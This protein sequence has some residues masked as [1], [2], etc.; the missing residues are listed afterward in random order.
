MYPTPEEQLAAAWRQITEAAADP[1]LASDTVERLDNAARLL[2]R[3]ERSLSRRLPFLLEASARA[4]LLLNELRSDLPALAADID[5]LSS[6]AS[7][8]SG[9][10]A[11]A[12]NLAWQRLL[13]RAVSELPVDDA[14]E[15]GISLIAA[16]LRTRSA[17][18][19][20]LHRHPTALPESPSAD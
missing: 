20:S 10:A 4:R 11:H 15:R 2:R 13:A 14:G 16:H 6:R 3:L 8:R 9:P 17:S 7:A 5:V 12:T 19:P 18:D 1:A